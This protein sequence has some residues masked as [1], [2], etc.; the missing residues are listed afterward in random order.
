MAMNG[1]HIHAILDLSNKYENCQINLIQVCSV[2]RFGNLRIL[3]FK[4][5]YAHG[6]SWTVHLSYLSF[7][8]TQSIYS[9]QIRHI[10]ILL[11]AV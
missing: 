10:L 6:M 5:H 7:V 11:K 8:V 1:S 2:C 4:N 9:E 3:N